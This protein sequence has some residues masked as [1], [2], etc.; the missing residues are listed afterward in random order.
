MTDSVDIKSLIRR[1]DRIAFSPAGLEPAEL[2]KLLENNLE[3]IGPATAILN[4]SIADCIDARKLS[5]QMHVMA[6]GGALTN[7]RFQQFG[8]L[9]IIP[10]NYSA[11][12]DLVADGTIGID[13]VLTQVA[14]SDASYNTSFMVDHVVEAIPTARVVIA[15]VNDRLPVVFGDTDIVREDIDHTV[16]VSRDPF[17]L[18][19]RPLS[20]TDRAIGE[21]VAKLIRDGDT[22]QV[23]LGAMPDAVLK[24]VTGHRNLGVHSGTIGDGVAELMKSGVITNTQKSIDPGVCVTAGLLGTNDLYQWAHQNSSL[25][26][27]SPRYTHSNDVHQQIDNLVGINTALEVDLT[28]Q[29]NAEVAAGQQIG[30]LGGHSDFMRGC[31]RSNGG[32]G[33][34][35]MHATGRGG[36]VS[37]ITPSIADGIVTTARQDADYVVTEYGVAALRGRS[38]SERASALIGIAHP[39]FRQSLEQAVDDGLV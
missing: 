11:L 19:A 4:V 26:V 13:V 37:R 12:P 2:L 8:A 16:T 21:H 6:L 35:A 30:M 17:E 25:Q 39:E 9:D 3:S 36:T 33:I 32:R 18:S 15:E 28:G 34:V 10:A 22:L 1:N 27:R 24:A 23:G 7:R 20:D 38:L 29:I 14:A 31:L 5:E